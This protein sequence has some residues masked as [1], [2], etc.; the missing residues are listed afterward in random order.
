MKYVQV[1]ENASFVRIFNSFLQ[2]LVMIL[3]LILLPIFFVSPSEIEEDGGDRA[4][5]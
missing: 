5:P 3:K 4:P 1:G 2:K